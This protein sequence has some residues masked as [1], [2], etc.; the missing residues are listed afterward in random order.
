MRR[1]WR[2]Y[3]SRWGWW[4]TATLSSKS[5]RHLSS[6][7]FCLACW[8]SASTTRTYWYRL[9]LSIPQTSCT[10][11][12]FRTCTSQSSLWLLS[13]RW[14]CRGVQCLA[15]IGLRP[16]TSGEKI[17]GMHSSGYT[18]EKSCRLWQTLYIHRSTTPTQL[19]SKG[20]KISK[21]HKN[22]TEMNYLS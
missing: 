17:W 22:L 13:C 19:L 4:R 21:N 8:P 10:Y 12:C 11:S 14:R 9:D 7:W 18:S 5:L 20:S 6:L 16:G 3:A 15:L 2:L 1:F